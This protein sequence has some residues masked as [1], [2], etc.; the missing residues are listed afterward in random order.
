MSFHILKNFLTNKIR[1]G[2]IY[3]P[4]AIVLLLKNNGVATFEQVAKLIYIFEYKYSLEDYKIIVKNFVST[5]LEEYSIA[6]IDY[7]NEKIILNLKN[8]KDEEKEELI[9]ISYKISKGFFRNLN[10]QEKAVV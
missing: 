2:D 4:S 6:N 10:S 5:M 7:K 8:I 3:V 1:K 9:S